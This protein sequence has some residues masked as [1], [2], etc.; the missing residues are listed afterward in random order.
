MLYLISTPIGN[1]KDI[2]I[3]ALEILKECDYILCEQIKHSLILL[4]TYN[5]KKSLKP[6]Y[7][8]NEK[9]REEEIIHDLRQ[10]KKIALISNAG[11]PAICDPGERLVQRCRH[12]SLPITALPGP[13]AW[14]TALSLSPFSKKKVQFLGFL[15]KKRGEKMVALASSAHVTTI[16][17]ESPHRLVSTLLAIPAKREVCVMKEL[18]KKFEQYYQGTAEELAYHF[19][20]N[21]P[22]KGEFVVLIKGEECDFSHLTTQE[23]LQLIQQEYQLPLKEALKLVARLRNV[24]K[25]SLYSFRNGNRKK[26]S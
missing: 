8:F 23:H 3:R 21:A 2:T 12:E 18:T 10:G 24:A 16:F 20:I 11:T 7:L 19:E 1:L 15:P 22:V 25:K 4:N 26:A 5:I 6:F 14:V 9:Q 13:S 17:Y